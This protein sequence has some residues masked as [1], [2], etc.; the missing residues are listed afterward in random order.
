MNSTTTSCVTSTNNNTNNNVYNIYNN[1]ITT[2]A[3]SSSTATA[4]TT[5]TDEASMGTREPCQ[6]GSAESLMWLNPRACPAKN[7]KDGSSSSTTCVVTTFQAPNSDIILDFGN[8]LC[9]FVHGTLKD[10]CQILLTSCN[11]NGSFEAHSSKIQFHVT[12]I[13]CAKTYPRQYQM[14]R[15]ACARIL[16]TIG[17]FVF[18]TPQ[19]HQLALNLLNGTVRLQLTAS[20]SR[21]IIRSFAGLF[22]YI[23]LACVAKL[24]KDIKTPYPMHCSRCQQESQSHENFQEIAGSKTPELAFCPSSKIYA[25][26]TIVAVVTSKQILIGSIKSQ[27]DSVISGILQ[28]WDLTEVNFLPQLLTSTGGKF[29]KIGKQ[30]YYW[31]AS[32]LIPSAAVLKKVN[33][34]ISGLCEIMKKLILKKEIFLSKDCQVFHSSNLAGKTRNINAKNEVLL[35]KDGTYGMQL[36]VTLPSDEYTN[37]MLAQ[38]GQRLLMHISRDACRKLLS[39]WPT[40]QPHLIVTRQAINTYLICI[41]LPDAEYSSR[42]ISSLRH[43]AVWLKCRF[44]AFV[45]QW[46]NASGCELVL[47]PLEYETD[48]AGVSRKRTRVHLN[49]SNSRK[50]LCHVKDQI[51]KV[52]TLVHPPPLKM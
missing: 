19:E 43:V 6:I 12:G 24:W 42:K 44:I 16:G 18:Q 2:T 1:N 45:E 29:T 48:G 31:R 51:A 10:V 41:S 26:V 33:G 25:L 27:L 14:H 28:A 35:V 21:N 32:C 39:T 11:N 3:I 5:N 15:F 52:M 47:N 34:A 37:I 49:A 38:G 30:F 36:C 9:T 22:K 4:T 17:R 7:V 23:V 40:T 50:K 20:S 46:I 8:N 13:F